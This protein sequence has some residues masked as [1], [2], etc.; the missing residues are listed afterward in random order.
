[1]AFPENNRPRTVTVANE[2]DRSWP[3]AL[4]LRAVDADRKVWSRD[5]TLA[6]GEAFALRL[7]V[8]A[9]YELAV[10][11]E[12]GATERVDVAVGS[13]DCNHV[14]TTARIDA[15][16][17][18]DVQTVTTEI[19]CPQASLA[20]TSISSGEADCGEA[21]SAT[22]AFGQSGVTVEGE[23]I[24][25]TPCHAAR[26]RDA[27]LSDGVLTVT[28]GTETT[29]ETC[30]QCLGA[31]PYTLE[32]DFDHDLPDA[33]VVR[34]QRDGRPRKVVRAARGADAWGE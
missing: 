6:A 22:V 18:L 25:P 17:G 31:V 33:I 7:N 12:G 10:A 5:R 27:T 24:A 11:V 23:I 34:H 8:P 20:G 2:S 1:M 28:V 30:V 15:D 3:V 21:D 26:L 16:G 9:N 19:A 13:F 32:C 4:A 29:D 14:S